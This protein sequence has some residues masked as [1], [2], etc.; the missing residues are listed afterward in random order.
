MVLNLRINTWWVLQVFSL[1]HIYPRLKA[2]TWKWMKTNKQTNKQACF[3]QSQDQ[4]EGSITKEKSFRQLSLFSIPSKSTVIKWET[5]TSILS[6]LNEAAQLLIAEIRESWV[7]SWDFC[8]SQMVM[9]FTPP[10]PLYSVTEEHVGNLGI[11]SPLSDQAMMRNT[12]H[13]LRGWYQKSLSGESG[14]SLLSSSN[15]A[16]LQGC[17]S[18]SYM[19]SNNKAFFFALARVVS[20]KENLDIFPLLQDS[21][22][23]LN[24]VF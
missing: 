4:E 7:G 16:T 9:L 1:P 2:G 22:S 5:L 14:L 24:F 13:S 8:P 12:T 11:V 21:G 23:Y 18:G 20:V 6:Q 15:K 3:L 17:I 19:R 10:L